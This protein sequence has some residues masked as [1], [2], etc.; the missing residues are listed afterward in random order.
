MQKEPGGKLFYVPAT[1][2]TTLEVLQKT[3]EFFSRRE[4]PS[5]RLEAELLLARAL[6]CKRLDLYLRFE[7]PLAE[8]QLELLRGLVAR[9]G[10]R[11]PPQYIAGRAGFLDFEVSCDARALIPRPETEQLAELIFARMTAPPTTALDLGTGTGVLAIAIARH[12][13]DCRVT[14]VEASRETLALAEANIAALSLA[15]RVGCRNA[16]WPEVFS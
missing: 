1:M 13:P 5:P 6:G 9:R 14:A 16:R 11:E 3:T 8:T 12:W 10:K 15:E 4:I 2:P 7:R